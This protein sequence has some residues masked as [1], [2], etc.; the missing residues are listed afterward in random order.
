MQ[1]RCLEA[2]ELVVSLLFNSGFSFNSSAACM[3]SLR[4]IPSH[5]S[6]TLNKREL[7]CLTVS[8]VLYESTPEGF[9]QQRPLMSYH[10]LEGVGLA[11]GVF[12][13]TSIWWFLMALIINSFK[14]RL[15]DNSLKMINTLLGIMV[16][17]FGLLM[18]GREGL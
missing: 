6:H 13:G 14:D 2:S 15:T 12:I 4:S 16:I 17:M 11:G 9:V 8:F 7:F 1:Y 18:I 5:L 3:F 10:T